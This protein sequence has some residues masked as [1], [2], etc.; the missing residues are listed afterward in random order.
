[1]CDALLKSQLRRPRKV[2][3]LRFCGTGGDVCPMQIQAGFPGVFGVTLV[4]IWAASEVMG[5]LN[6]GLEPGPVSRIM[7]GAEVRLVDDTGAPVRPG[8][9]GELL[10]RGPNVTIGYWAGPDAIE[11]APED[12]WWRSGDLMRQDK[13]G[14]LWFVSR[15]KDLIIRGGSNISPVEVERVLATHPAVIDVAVVG[16]P[17]DV[18]GQRVAAFVQLKEGA[19]PTVVNDILKAAK[20]QLADYK[21]PELLEAIAAIPRNVQGKADRK[22]LVETLVSRRRGAAA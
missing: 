19:A 20:S 17:D 15:K 9:V 11:N 18:F 4:S 3:S 8:E 10:L 13:K 7:E 22:A 16:M 5:S 6:Y 1:M 2:D 12:G 21:V 14:D